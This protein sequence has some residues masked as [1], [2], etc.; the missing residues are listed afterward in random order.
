M[1]SAALR[2]KINKQMNLRF[3]YY[4]SINR[5]GFYELVPYQ[6]DGEDYTEKG[7]PLLKRSRIDNID[8]AGALRTVLQIS[9]GSYR[10]KL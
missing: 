10:D 3:N 2:W 9:Q 1:P 8:R 6:L 5:P 4:K 7:N